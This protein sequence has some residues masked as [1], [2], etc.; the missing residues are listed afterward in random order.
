M[1]NSHSCYITNE[2]KW[3][4]TLWTQTLRSL[5]GSLFVISEIWLSD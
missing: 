5:Q 2:E 4:S 3:A 1:V